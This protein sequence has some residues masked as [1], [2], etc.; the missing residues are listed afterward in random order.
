M[1]SGGF[2]T[3]AAASETF[4]RP[5][6]PDAPSPSLYAGPLVPPAPLQRPESAGMIP[7]HMSDAGLA[8]GTDP[9]DSDEE[10]HDFL[11]SSN[12]AGP[13]RECNVHVFFTCSEVRVLLLAIQA[14]LQVR[15]L[16]FHTF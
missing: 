2:G 6:E 13:T 12:D 1:G 7:T 8:M 15:S 4:M 3:G 9:V 5:L 14:L 10:F 11:V 16:I